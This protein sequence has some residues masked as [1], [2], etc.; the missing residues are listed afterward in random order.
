M[1]NETTDV[2][3]YKQ[4]FDWISAYLKSKLGEPNNYKTGKNGAEQQ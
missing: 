4:K 1:N 2:T 3:L